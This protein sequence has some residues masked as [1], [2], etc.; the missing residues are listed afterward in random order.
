ML[1][2]ATS[3]QLHRASRPAAELVEVFR[4]ELRCVLLERPRYTIMYVD[5]DRDFLASLEAFLPD[6]LREALPRFELEFE[7]FDEPL[8]A[9]DACKGI[10]SRLAVVV[11]DQVMP[12]VSGID[13]LT[14]VKE[15]HPR[16]RCVLLTGQA[17]LDSAV[18]AINRRILH[19]YVFKPVDP[20]DFSET[21]RLLLSE[22]HLGLRVETRQDR[23]MSQFEYIR[24]VTSASKPGQVLS[25]TLSFLGEQV[26][27]AQV[28]VALMQNGE[29]VLRSARPRARAVNSPV[30]MDR[31]LWGWLAKHRRPIRAT[32]AAELPEDACTDLPLPLMAAPMLRDN[33]FLGAIVVSGNPCGAAFTREAAMLLSFVADVA[34]VAVG[35]F[36]DRAEVEQSYVSTMAS[37][38]ETVEAKDSYTRGHTERVMVLAMELARSLGIKDQLLQQIEWAAA[39]HDIGKISLPDAILQKP[40]PLTAHEYAIMKAHTTRGDRILRHLKYLQA[41]RII[42]RS[43]HE[44]Y[45][46]TG[47]PDG[48][49]GEEIPFGARIL[50]IADSYDAMTSHRPYR[51]AMDPGEAL[52]RIQAGAGTQFDPQLAQRFLEMMRSR[53]DLMTLAV[54]GA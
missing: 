4:E 5:D 44:R 49:A 45:D 51:A 27:A 43:H 28:Q 2:G 13:L 9:L 32:T 48:L 40:G 1:A 22:Y 37:L 12:N 24:A 52:S 38:M 54:E 3:D 8:L 33:V 41:A 47:Y 36:G 18:G 39:L 26:G 46:G 31:S 10:G 6:R 17:G 42:I 35:S 30:P 7:F 23:M 15:L 16:V 29:M 21:I 20:V 53:K 11:S 50:A 34:A 19:K 14:R 25:N